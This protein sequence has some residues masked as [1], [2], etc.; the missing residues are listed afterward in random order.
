MCY[1]QSGHD[2]GVHEF[3]EDIQ[4]LG[5]NLRENEP[6]RDPA[7]PVVVVASI[8]PGRFRRERQN[9]PAME[10]LF[11]FSVVAMS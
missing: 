7:R 10:L 9:D 8:N 4:R 11:L 6:V 2:R 5:G 1:R 3:A